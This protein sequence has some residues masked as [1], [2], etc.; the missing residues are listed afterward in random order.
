M[1]KKKGYTLSDKHSVLI[2]NVPL[3]QKETSPPKL[4]PQIPHVDAPLFSMYVTDINER[5]KCPTQSTFKNAPDFFAMNL[6]KHCYAKNIARDIAHPNMSLTEDNEY[7][8]DIH[9]S[10]LQ[11]SYLDSTVTPASL[12]HLGRMTNCKFI[13]Y[14]LANI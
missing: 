2:L 4:P 14:I 13:S 10:I 6:R 7:F 9:K 12:V 8:K 3:D 1:Y 11:L 5:R